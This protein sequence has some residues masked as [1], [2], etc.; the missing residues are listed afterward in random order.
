MLLVSHRSE[1]GALFEEES[2]RLRSALGDNIL[3]VEHVG[4]TAVEGMDA[5][6]LI[7]MMAAVRSLD[8][9][10]ALVPM[11]ERMGSEHLVDGGM[12]KTV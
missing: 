7:D 6:P 4:S 1:W 2:A 9:A 8:E 5:K 3:R 10:S 11:L 12:I